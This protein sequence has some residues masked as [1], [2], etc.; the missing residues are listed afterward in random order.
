MWRTLCP[1]FLF[2]SFVVP[3][4]A[5]D[6]GCFMWNTATYFHTA[7]IQ[8]VK[9]CLEEERAPAAAAR[10]DGYTPLHFAAR[11]NKD[12]AVVHALLAHGADL[13][14]KTKTGA[15]GITPLHAAAA[16]NPNLEVLQALL[17]AGADPMMRDENGASLLFWAALNDTLAAIEIL[18]RTGMD[19]KALDDH[20]ATPLHWAA[21]STGNSEV[22]QALLAAGAA[23]N[24]RDKNKF[25][26]LLVAAE[27]NVHPGVVQALL[28]AG[29]DLNVRDDANQTPLH[30]AAASNVHP[31]VVR[32]LLAAGADLNVRDDTNQTPLERAASNRNPRVRQALLAAGTVREARNEDDDTSQPQAARHYQS[33][34]KFPFIQTFLRLDTTEK[35][36]EHLR[37]WHFKLAKENGIREHDARNYRTFLR[38]SVFPFV[39]DKGVLDCEALGSNLQDA[40]GDR[41]IDATSDMVMFNT[42]VDELCPEILALPWI[43]Q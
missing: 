37:S 28:A 11:Y 22:I 16:Y 42:T 14:A 21:G 13:H 38:I 34:V 33:S 18:L 7:T 9:G 32:A 2:F 20:G 15:G 3:L 39:D 6:W 19:P 23:I 8:N 1:M 30:L 36:L 29:A 25:T 26:P 31:G 24:A 10:D 43:F 40:W 5:Q 4:A 17:G 41:Y 35:K 12:P 27:Y